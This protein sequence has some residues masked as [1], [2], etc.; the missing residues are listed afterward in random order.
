ERVSAKR[1]PAGAGAA[2]FSSGHSAEVRNPRAHQREAALPARSDSL[3]SFRCYRAQKA[4]IPFPP[5]IIIRFF[6]IKPITLV[7]FGEKDQV[8]LE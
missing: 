4:P 5:S 2:F 3:P 6:F 8:W 1:H 7:F